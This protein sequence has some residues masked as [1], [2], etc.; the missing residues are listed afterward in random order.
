[1][2]G[3][4]S[5]NFRRSVWISLGMKHFGNFWEDWKKVP[6]DTN[7]KLKLELSETVE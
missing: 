6:E 4:L 2:L 1:M 3:F 7:R 5:G